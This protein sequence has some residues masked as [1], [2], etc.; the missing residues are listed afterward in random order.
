MP[1]LYFNRFLVQI[2]SFREQ[3]RYRTFAFGFT[4]NIFLAKVLLLIPE[5]QYSMVAVSYTHLDVYKRQTATCS[6]GAASPG[7]ARSA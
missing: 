3:S 5:A 4:V 7:T 6:A 1:L 2:N